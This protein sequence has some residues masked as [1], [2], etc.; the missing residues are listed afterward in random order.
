VGS[1]SSERGDT[2]QSLLR[3]YQQQSLASIH[4]PLLL[5]DTLIAFE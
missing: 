2:D 3:C 1:L 4:F 5:L